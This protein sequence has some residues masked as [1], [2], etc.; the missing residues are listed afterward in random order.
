MSEI[1]RD[2]SNKYRIIAADLRLINPVTYGNFLSSLNILFKK[3]NQT[4]RNTCFSIY[5]LIFELPAVHL[6]PEHM[7][8]HYETGF[9]QNTINTE[10]KGTN[11]HEYHHFED[12]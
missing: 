9:H 4:I 11:Q 5:F 10:Q 7:T 1:G 6:M 12:S 3:Q 2:T 8:Y